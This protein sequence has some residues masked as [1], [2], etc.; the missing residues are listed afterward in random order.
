MPITVNSTNVS[1]GKVRVTEEKEE[2]E[3]NIVEGTREDMLNQID[4]MEEFQLKNCKDC[5]FAESKKVGTGEACCTYPDR[6]IVS[7]T[8]GECKSK[9]QGKPRL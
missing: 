8:T 2:L 9:R 7:S 5:F 3:M 4:S 6:L 1:G